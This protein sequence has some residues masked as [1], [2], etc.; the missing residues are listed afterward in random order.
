MGYAALKSAQNIFDL[1]IKVPSGPSTTFEGRFSL[2]SAKGLKKE[3][4]ES[5]TEMLAELLSVVRSPKSTDEKP[6]YDR[7]RYLL[8]NVITAVQGLTPFGV[9][10]AYVDFR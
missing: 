1:S 9:D 10:V 8:E 6:D 7:I 4:L 5:V 2:A 3:H